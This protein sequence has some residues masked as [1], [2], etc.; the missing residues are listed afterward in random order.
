MPSA[1]SKASSA[2]PVEQPSTLMV[3]SGGR[4]CAPSES[5][6]SRTCSGPMSLT[7]EISETFMGGTLGHD[8]DGKSK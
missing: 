3:S 2:L 7:V 1:S 4:V 8:S 5:R 6:K